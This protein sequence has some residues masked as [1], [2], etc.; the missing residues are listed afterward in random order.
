MI[1]HD[2]CKRLSKRS[3]MPTREVVRRPDPVLKTVVFFTRITYMRCA[4][5]SSLRISIFTF[6]GLKTVYYVQT[7]SSFSKFFSLPSS[8]RVYILSIIQFLMR[9]TKNIY[10]FRR[11]PILKMA[12]GK[13]KS[14]M[15]FFPN[16]RCVLLLLLL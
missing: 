13:K 4:S 1:E 11:L 5:Y 3:V 12:T 2:L 8:L 9:V 16:K 6:N 10:R 7:K 14:E 15:T